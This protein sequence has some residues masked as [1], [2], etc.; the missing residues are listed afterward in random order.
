[1]DDWPAAEKH[2]E[3]ALE[4]DGRDPLILLDYA[5]ALRA[6]AERVDDA[7]ERAGLIE[8]AREHLRQSLA[9]RER[10]AET[11]AAMAATHLLEGQDAAPGVSHINRAL[12]L[13]PASLEARLLRGRLLLKMRS[14]MAAR[15]DAITVLTRARKRSNIESARSLL[16]AI[17]S[18]GLALEAMF[19]SATLASAGGTH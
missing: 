8:R 13:A 7:D 10:L 14:R 18:S 4:L 19:D 9:L 1:M 2:F 3:K 5:N 16:E 11:H 15:S 12:A 17:E 6:R